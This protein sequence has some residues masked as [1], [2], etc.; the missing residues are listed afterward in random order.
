[1]I[2][3]QQFINENKEKD[4]FKKKQ[5]EVILKTNPM[6]D[7]IHQG[8]RKVEDIKTWAECQE[9]YKTDDEGFSYPDNQF[10]KICN[11]RCSFVSIYSSYDIKPGVFVSTSK[12][13]A[14]D[15]AGPSGKVWHIDVRPDEVAWM[16]GDEGMYVGK[17]NKKLI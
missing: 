11:V 1:M 9:Y 17:L 4:D 12:M 13:M 14:Q 2:S 15:Y 16:N 3:L 6:H 10:K 8:I 7:D 5:L